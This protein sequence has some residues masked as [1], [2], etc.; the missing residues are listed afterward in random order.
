M[1]LCCA[2]AIF[3]AHCIKAAQLKRQCGLAGRDSSDVSRLVLT[4]AEFTLYLRPSVT[5]LCSWSSLCLNPI[6]DDGK[7]THAGSRSDVR[8]VR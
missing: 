2:K 1:F 8:H 6:T 3:G 5:A 4:W 7:Q